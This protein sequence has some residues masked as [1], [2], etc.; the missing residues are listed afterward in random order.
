MIKYGGEVATS[1]TSLSGIKNLRFLIINSTTELSEQQKTF[2]LKNF[3][4]FSASHLF[5]FSYFVC[6]LRTSQIL[7][8]FLSS[9]KLLKII[10]LQLNLTR[11][12]ILQPHILP[13]FLVFSSICCLQKWKILWLVCS[14]IFYND[15]SK[16]C[17]K[18]LSRINIF[19]MI[20]LVNLSVITFS[21]VL[22]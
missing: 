3:Y 18:A 6:F 8:R 2:H 5:S 11:L 7:V 20:L 1:A 19:F 22:P 12:T 15:F 9:L 13:Q 16:F 21:G 4:N 17:R 14:K 10:Q